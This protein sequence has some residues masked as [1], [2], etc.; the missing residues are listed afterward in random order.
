[1]GCTAVARVTTEKEQ[2]TGPPP[3]LPARYNGLQLRDRYRMSR[4]Q[5]FRATRYIGTLILCIG[6]RTLNM[7]LGRG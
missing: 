2:K 3:L 4:V 5:V 7:N 6:E 1:M